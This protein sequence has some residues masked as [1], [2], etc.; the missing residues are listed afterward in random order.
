MTKWDTQPDPRQA[1]FLKAYLDPK[2]DTFSNAYQSAIKVGYAD[3]YAKSILSKD[4]DWLAENVKNEK[5]LKKAERNIDEL[6]DEEEDKRIKLDI[7]KFVAERLGRF[8]EKKDVNV[9]GEI[10]DSE[11]NLDD[12]VSEV[13][14][15]LKD[16]KFNGQKATDKTNGGE[17][18]NDMVGQQ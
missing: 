9:Q 6:L 14:I 1:L 8:V 7:T 11:N 18:H 5:L 15:R 12:I 16:K 17:K 13:L 4:L 2:S 10:I 3:E